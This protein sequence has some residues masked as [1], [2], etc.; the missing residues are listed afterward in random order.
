MSIWDLNEQWYN[1]FLEYIGS[2]GLD[3]DN[4]IDNLT[5][6]LLDE[7]IN[8]NTR[9]YLM[10]RDILKEQFMLAGQSIAQP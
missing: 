5:D 8:A 9:H 7:A 4:L 6:E 1:Y 10:D 2:R 3:T